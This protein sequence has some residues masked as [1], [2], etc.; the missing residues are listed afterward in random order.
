VSGISATPPLP[1]AP[2]RP[3][4]VVFVAR[5][6]P[7]ALLLSVVACGSGIP[8]RYYT[9]DGPSVASVAGDGPSSLRVGVGRVVVA[10]P[11]DQDRIA[12]RPPDARHELAFY[13]YHRWAV[14]PAEAL[15]AGLAGALDRLEGIRA[16]SVSGA[17]GAAEHD[18]VL[19]VRVTR[20]EEVDDSEAS[21]RVVLA[22]EVA[23]AD[24]D[25]SGPLALELEAPVASRTVESVVAAF[26]DT[27]DQ[28]ARRI[29]LEL[30]GR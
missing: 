22:L 16:E 27:L 15:R 12:Y 14:P 2:N 1:A 6:A 29:A 3:P 11:Y 8:I 10:A 30:L 7:L 17:S 28:A 13:H 18:V 26:A 4:A 5:L 23:R 24:G 20:V 21:V 9:L 19:D 25:G